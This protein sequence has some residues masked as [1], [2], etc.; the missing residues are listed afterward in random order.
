[1]AGKRFDLLSVTSLYLF[2]FTSKDL[3]FE[4]LSAF[5][6]VDASNLQ[7]LCGIQPRIGAP[8]HDC[9]IVDFHLVD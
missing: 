6:L 9:D 5:A 8:P 4:Y 7:D 2:M 3:L 1:M